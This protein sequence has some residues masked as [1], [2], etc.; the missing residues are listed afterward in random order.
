MSPVK[1]V[2]T[3]S[4]LIEDTPSTGPYSEKMAT[5]IYMGIPCKLTR[6]FLVPMY[7][8]SSLI[9]LVVRL[10]P[11]RVFASSSV[12]SRMPHMPLDLQTNNLASIFNAFMASSIVYPL[13]AIHFLDL[14]STVISEIFLVATAT[15]TKGTVKITLFNALF[16]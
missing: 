7:F 14:T 8:V 13:T 4:D 6:V 5:V 9:F 11:A 10:I 3:M 12:A 2:V 15:I 1:S 16:F